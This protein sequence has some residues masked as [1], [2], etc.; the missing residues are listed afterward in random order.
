MS[1]ADRLDETLTV[2]VDRGDVSG[3]VVMAATPSGSVYSGAFGM[4]DVGDSVPMKLDNIFRIHSMTKIVT[5]VAVMQLV[6]DGKIGLDARPGEYLPELAAAPVIEAFD[7]ES[8]DYSLRKAESSMTVRHLL[9]HTSGLGY[10]IWSPIVRDFEPRD[11][12]YPAGPLLFDPGTAWH[13]GTSFDWLGRLVELLS[14]QSLYAYFRERIFTPLDMLDTHFNV[15]ESEW[16]RI[17]TEHRREANGTLSELPREDPAVVTELKGGGGLFSTA[18]DYMKLLRM[19]LRDGELD[20]ARILSRETVRTM[21]QNH[22]GDLAVLALKTA[23]RE[24]SSDFAFV[25]DGRDKFGL[26]FLIHASAKEGGRS[27]GSLAWGGLRNTYFWLDI[28]AG[29][30]GV[31]MSQSLP[32]SDPRALATLDAF[33][34]GVYDLMAE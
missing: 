22:I 4:A 31:I 15:P 2:A 28:K 5:S 27:S 17:V 18:E 10:D 24:Q 30:A 16:A 32:F 6:E 7:S 13:Y 19:L 3:V 11:A 8:G 1:D 33:E 9:T 14:G 21:A 25:D 12:S 20:G 34:R 23:R 26:G 29:I